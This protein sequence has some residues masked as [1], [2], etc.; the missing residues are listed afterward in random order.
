MKKFH[1]KKGDQVKV[2]SGN[3]K[4]KQGQVLEVIGS[5]SRALV[6]SVNI[7]KRHTKPSAQFPEG[8]IIE[9]EGSIHISNLMLVDA[10]G[11]PVRKSSTKA[12]AVA[13][14]AAKKPAAKK[15][16]AKKPAAKKPAAKK[17][18]SKTTKKVKEENK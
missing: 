5:K 6:E 13:K 15:P 9:K 16:A 18:V 11:E 2:I 3:H 12:K 8:G 4:G 17:A 14:P 1:I 10:S 7:V